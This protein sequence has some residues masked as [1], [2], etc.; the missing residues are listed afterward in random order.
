MLGSNVDEIPR[1]WRPE[2]CW[3]NTRRRLAY[4]QSKGGRTLGIGHPCV[5]AE[6]D[7]FANMQACNSRCICR[8][9]MLSPGDVIVG[10]VHARGQRLC[11]V[12]QQQTDSSDSRREMEKKE[13]GFVEMKLVVS[14]LRGRTGSVLVRQTVASG[15]E[16]E[17][18][19]WA[20][21]THRQLKSRSVVGRDLSASA[22]LRW[23]CS[24]RQRS[25]SG[26]CCCEANHALM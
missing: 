16:R 25:N 6:A 24:V 3:N 8:V 10:G 18:S 17:D 14:S 19:A 5:S 4:R 20:A 1:L 15:S 9:Q 7:S 26:D 22:W 23:A 12:L 21:I 2:L 13:S 11:C